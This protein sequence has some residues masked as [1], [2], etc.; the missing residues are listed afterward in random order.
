[1]PSTVR[2]SEPG[3]VAPPPRPRASAR[4][5]KPTPILPEEAKVMMVF[6]VAFVAVCALVAL[7]AFGGSLSKLSSSTASFVARAIKLAVRSNVSISPSLIES[8]I[9]VTS[10][11][12]GAITTFCL[13]TIIPWYHFEKKAREK[14]AKKYAL[15]H[16]NDP[17]PP[18]PERGRTLRKPGEPLFE[19]KPPPEPVSIKQALKDI[20]PAKKTLRDG[21]SKKLPFFDL[22]N[23]APEDEQGNSYPRQTTYK[24]KALPHLGA[25]SGER[26]PQ[27]DPKSI[28]FAT[29][30]P[31]QQLANFPIRLKKWLQEGENQECHFVVLRKPPGAEGYVNLFME[32]MVFPFG[33]AM[34]Q[35]KLIRMAISSESRGIV[36][37]SDSEP[38]HAIPIN[39]TR[40]FSLSVEQGQS[41]QTHLGSDCRMYLKRNDPISSIYLGAEVEGR[42]IGLHLVVINDPNHEQVKNRLEIAIKQNTLQKFLRSVGRDVDWAKDIQKTFSDPEGVAPSL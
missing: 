27:C 2:R 28:A 26:G 37:H 11:S 24:M 8:V 3:P 22:T 34:K 15:R 6:A 10:V 4:K 36:D 31:S 18:P 29:Q 16:R 38:N 40:P 1:M 39:K 42:K 20:E 9:K 12:L 14:A 5:S 35:Q 32:P 21:K 17:P 13:L 30:L 41:N 23:N 33:G 19:P 25:G 7:L